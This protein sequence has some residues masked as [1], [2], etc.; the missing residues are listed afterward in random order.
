MIARGGRSGLLLAVGNM[1]PPI[2][3]RD[4][5]QTEGKAT[6]QS[7]TTSFFRFR[8]ASCVEQ[9]DITVRKSRALRRSR[10][11]KKHVKFSM[12]TFVDSK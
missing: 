6:F 4:G 12:T 9:S 8:I 3:T 2:S 10:N 11:N 7:G 1:D 5:Q